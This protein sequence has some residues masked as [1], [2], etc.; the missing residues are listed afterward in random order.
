MLNTRSCR[1]SFWHSCLN[2]YSTYHLTVFFLLSTRVLKVPLELCTRFTSITNNNN[3]NNN[4]YYYIR[5]SSVNK[6]ICNSKSFT[7]CRWSCDMAHHERDCE[8]RPRRCG[9][10][11]C[12][13]VAH[14]RNEALDH[15]RDAHAYYVWIHFEDKET[16]LEWKEHVGTVFGQS[17]RYLCWPL[18]HNCA[19]SSYTFASNCYTYRAYSFYSCFL[20]LFRMA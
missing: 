9:K 5:A 10:R 14:N 17:T 15:L 18:V 1:L 11:G 6:K 20:C 4:Y 13:F 7:Y 2:K 16:E 3:N 12:E 8:K 19:D